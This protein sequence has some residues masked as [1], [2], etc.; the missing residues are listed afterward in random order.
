MYIK[1]QLVQFYLTDCDSK[2]IWPTGLWVI[3]KA[4]GQEELP[5]LSCYTRRFLHYCLL[6]TRNEIKYIKK[7]CQ[8]MS[9]CSPLSGVKHIVRGT[10]LI[11]KRTVQYLTQKNISHYKLLIWI[12]LPKSKQ[13]LQLYTCF[14]LKARNGRFNCRRTVH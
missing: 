4:E 2:R 11:Y 1:F 6:A 7:T 14:T 12:S 5:N 13:H 3:G 9:V 8:L 10:L